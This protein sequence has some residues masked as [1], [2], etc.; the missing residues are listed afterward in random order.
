MFAVSF[1]FGNFKLEDGWEQILP[2]QNNRADVEK[3][4]GKP[5][6][7]SG[8]RSLYDTEYVTIAFDF[9]GEPCSGEAYGNLNVPKNT[10]H[11]Y[12]ISFK[13]DLLVSDL[14]WDSS[15]YRKSE[16]ITGDYSTFYRDFTSGINYESFKFNDKEKVMTIYYDFPSNKYKH[17]ECKKSAN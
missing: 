17:L 9:T 4:L 10:V 8:F 3:K 13:K 14:N 11:N 12:F 6:E 7:E 2:M 15:K 1:S 5:I 16:P